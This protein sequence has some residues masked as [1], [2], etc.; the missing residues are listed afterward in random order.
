MKHY[1]I[2]AAGNQNKDWLAT[3]SCKNWYYIWWNKI[4]SSTLCDWLVGQCTYSRILPSLWWMSTVTSTMPAD[5]PHFD[6]IWLR[7]SFICDFLLHSILFFQIF[8]IQFTEWIKK[9]QK[10]DLFQSD[11]DFYCRVQVYKNFYG[12]E[13]Y[14][15]LIV[16]CISVLKEFLK[17][18]RGKFWI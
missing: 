18:R 12:Y 4:Y 6:F 7:C 5:K 8:P 3:R 9:R 14:K 11:G 10:I 2:C 1:F 13:I 16:F 17:G 15:I